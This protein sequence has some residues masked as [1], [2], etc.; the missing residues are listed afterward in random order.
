MNAPSEPLDAYQLVAALTGHEVDFVVIGGVALQAHG[1]VRTTVDLDVVAAWTPEN[2]RNLARVLRGLGAQLRGVDADLL[3]L[4]LGDPDTLYGGGNFLMHTRHGDLDVLAIDQTAGAPARYEDLRARAIA[5][6]IRGV[7]LLIAHP[8]DLIR[9]K[10]A[11]A[12]FRDRPAA[13]RRQDLDDIAVLERLRAGQRPGPEQTRQATPA[14]TRLGPAQRET[15]SY[16]PLR[17]EGP[18]L[19]R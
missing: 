16:K 12:Q 6:E 1:H 19:R 13:K 2:M 9:M 4:D 14:P 3:G 10:T 8:D 11:A 18:T 7:T 5:V 15:S 17:R